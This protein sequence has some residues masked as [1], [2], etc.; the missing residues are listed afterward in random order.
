MLRPLPAERPEPLYWGLDS[1]GGGDVKLLAAHMA[2]LTDASP[3][4]DW[5]W[6]FNHAVRTVDVMGIVIG[7]DVKTAHV[8]FTLDDGTGLIDCI[9][10]GG[11]DEASSRPMQPPLGAL[12]RTLGRPST[13]RG[14]RQVTADRYW[15]EPDP[16]AECWHWLR[17]SQL[18][19]DCYSRPFRV[20]AG[21][22][23][24]KNSPAAAASSSGAAAPPVCLAALLEA[25]SR[26][27]AAAASPGDG[28]CQDDITRA[29]GDALRR[30][31]AAAI[32]RGL[33]QVCRN[34][35]S[36]VEPI[37]P[38]SLFTAARERRAPLPRAAARRG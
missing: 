16:M 25:A 32:R 19:R 18:W 21:A 23:E 37:R 6:L 33:D 22:V 30:C 34:A 20:P 4:G 3:N 7:V 2:L 13:F 26:A 17:A 14:T 10:W 29:G 12:V 31:G 15:I 5:L 1:L 36:R 35:S 24:P 38:S 28:V 8:K 27:A 9:A 11:S